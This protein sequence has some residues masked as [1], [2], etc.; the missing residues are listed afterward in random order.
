MLFSRRHLF[1][2]AAALALSAGLAAPAPVR[3]EDEP[4][5]VF[6][7]ASLKEA[8]T[9][10]AQDFETASGNKVQVSFAASGALARQIEA[11]APADVFVSANIK[12]MTYVSDMGLTVKESEKA[13]LGNALVLIAPADA[14]TPPVAIGPDF[15]LAGLLGEGHLAIGEMTTVPA[16]AYGK[17][18]LEKLGLFDSVK[19]RLAQASSVRAALALVGRGEAPLGIVYA[20]DAAADDKVKVIGTFPADSYP[21]IVYP[22]AILKE[23]NN[24]AAAAFIAYLQSAPAAATFTKAGFTVVQAPA[25]N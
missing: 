8:M 19:D 18:A 7:A 16:G 2:L 9:E 1:G 21:T 24:P 25:T 15:D 22:V 6:A 13:L 17:A 14:D 3:A 4:L 23:G 12:W 10:A 5:L 11:G 20:T